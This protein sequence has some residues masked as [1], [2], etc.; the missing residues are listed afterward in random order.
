MEFHANQQCVT[1]SVANSTEFSVWSFPWFP[2][3]YPV[4]FLH[5]CP[6]HLF[7]FLLRGIARKPWKIPWNATRNPTTHTPTTTKYRRGL[8]R[9]CLAE[10]QYELK[11]DRRHHPARAVIS[12]NTT[13]THAQTTVEE[14]VR[15]GSWRQVEKE[16]KGHPTPQLFESSLIVISA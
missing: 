13:A 4:Q 14:K 1:K 12:Y 5:G 10:V 16:M 2:I 7:S 15:V 9:H 6:W 8:H 11:S 3:E